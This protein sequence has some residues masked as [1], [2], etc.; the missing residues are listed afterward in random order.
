MQPEDQAEAA[1][2]LASLI[3]SDHI[4][5]HSAAYGGAG[6]DAAIRLALKL[7]LDRPDLGFIWLAV[8]DSTVVG[9][10]T[11]CFAVSTN[12]GAIVAKLPDFV[13]TANARGRGIGRFMVTSLVEELRSIGIGRVDLGV[14]ETN[15]GARRFYD[16]LGFVVN[17]ELGMSLV[18]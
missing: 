1:A 13:V 12:L 16:R 18:L 8:E 9:L 4:A 17:H 7:F 5:E 10:V 2:L 14:H 6:E 15:A 3:R 11:V